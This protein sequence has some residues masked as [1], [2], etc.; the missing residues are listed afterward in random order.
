MARVNLPWTQFD[1]TVN[2][3]VP[4]GAE[5]NGDAV[6]FHSVINDGNVK[7]LVRNSGATVPRTVTVRLSKTVDGQAAASRTHAI[8][9]ST[10][11]WL[12]PWPVAEYGDPVLIDVDNAELKLTA[13]RG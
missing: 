3:G 10:S 6:N 4:V 9:V 5:V 1:R 7:V 8:P 2:A 13:Y 11:R 12:G